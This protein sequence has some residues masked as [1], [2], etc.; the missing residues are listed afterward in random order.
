M[1]VLLNAYVKYSTKYHI[2]SYVV[3]EEFTKTGGTEKSSQIAINNSVRDDTAVFTC[4]AVNQYGSDSQDVNVAVQE[5]P[6]PPT[7][8]RGLEVGARSLSLAWTLNYF[9]NSVVV[10]HS[11]QYKRKSG[12][13][14]AYILFEFVVCVVK[15]FPF[16]SIYKTY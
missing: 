16:M 4:L 2:F 15:C 5:P 3:R 10:K 9:G 6:D 7:G 12:N 14:W 8:L 13:F 1:C 11:I